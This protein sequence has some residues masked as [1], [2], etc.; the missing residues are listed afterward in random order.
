MAF[1]STVTEQDLDPRTQQYLQG[2]GD[3]PAN[4]EP[5]LDVDGLSGGFF[6]RIFGL[7]GGGR[8]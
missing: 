3:D 8:S 7:F 1:D 2:L 4:R 6:A 5:D